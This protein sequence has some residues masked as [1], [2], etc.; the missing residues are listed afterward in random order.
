MGERPF[1]N[2]SLFSLLLSL[3]PLPPNSVFF[4]IW[5]KAGKGV[6]QFQLGSP[7]SIARIL[8]VSSREKTHS[9]T[10]MSSGI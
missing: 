5:R 3:Y 9:S 7:S 4:G 10:A 1:E 2:E 8:S 6:G